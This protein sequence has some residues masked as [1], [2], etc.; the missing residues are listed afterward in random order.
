MT[1]RNDLCPCESGKK[2]KRCCLLLAQGIKSHQSLLSG[3][4]A[5][6]ANITVLANNSL[7]EITANPHNKGVE[8]TLSDFQ[9]L[10]NMAVSL[11]NISLLSSKRSK[12][13]INSCIEDKIYRED[14]N[15][16]VRKMRSESN[17]TRLMIASAIGEPEKDTD[18]EYPVKMEIYKVDIDYIED[19]LE[20]LLSNIMETVEFMILHSK[21]GKTEIEHHKAS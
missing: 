2:F 13:V 1:G 20:L 17:I 11:W 21:R 12:E 9:L 4:N 6:I 8:Y 15:K 18:G 3:E 5:V 19:N 7:S 14:V 16:M 10:V